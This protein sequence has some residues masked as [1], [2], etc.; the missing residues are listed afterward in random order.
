[1]GQEAASVVHV[2]AREL[3][4]VQK[5]VEEGS[6]SGGGGAKDATAAVAA[7][8][9]DEGE[10]EE[11]VL[12]IGF[13]DSQHLVHCLA[14]MRQALVFNYARFYPHGM[15]SVQH[16]HLAHCQES[17]VQSLTCRPSLEVIPAT[18]MENQRFFFSD[19]DL[20]R[21]CLDWDAIMAWQQRHRI[22]QSGPA[23]ENFTQ[24]FLMPPE[25]AARRKSGVLNDERLYHTFPRVGEI[26]FL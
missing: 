9:G 7:A 6:G 17:L 8:A 22:D 19:F 18:W 10:D 11:E 20:P 26:S 21:K 2:P 15:T 4:R 13:L 24:R 12:Y 1:M 16:G 23:A 5:E 3:L 25:G 14:M